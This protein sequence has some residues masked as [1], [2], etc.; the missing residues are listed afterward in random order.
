MKLPLASILCLLTVGS[1]NAA[2]IKAYA[3]DFEKAELGKIPEEFLVL[4]GGFT[5]QEEGGNK[6][7]EL[8]GAPLDSYGA[9]FGSVEKEGQAVGAR[10]F[11]TS[12]GRRSPTFG[13]GL[14][15]AGGYR[16]QVSPGKKMLELYRGET[17]KLAVPFE[18]QSGKWT[19]LKLQI[20]KAGEDEWKVEGKA[21]AEGGKE[22]AEP[23]VAIVE[24]D[25]PPQGK[26]SIFA[27]PY[28]TTPIRFDD[29]KVEPAKP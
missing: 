26:S 3:N 10:I 9:L 27:S 29:L 19:L 20:V 16:L 28:A 7:L 1:A 5:V 18:W 8:P 25:L 22:P 11:G 17:V 14:N 12:K 23:S 24:K 4:D 6:F 13:V 15:G 21:W 2:D